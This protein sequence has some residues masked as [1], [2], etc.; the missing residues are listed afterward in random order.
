M[1]RIILFFL[2][3]FFGGC[4]NT[5]NG[6]FNYKPIARVPTKITSYPLIDYTGIEHKY[7]D[8]FDSF[9]FPQHNQKLTQYCAF[10]YEWENIKVKYAKDENGKWGYDYIV[11][12]DKRRNR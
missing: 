11:S 5:P 2:F 4:T 10:H 9:V 6:A 1:H 7:R 3:G 12:K 8:N